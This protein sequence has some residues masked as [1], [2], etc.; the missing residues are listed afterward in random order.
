M[1]SVALVNVLDAARAL[2][3][4]PTRAT[5]DTVADWFR[6]EYLPKRGGSFNY[7]PSMNSTYDLFRGGLKTDEAVMHC[8]SNGNPKGRS[9]NADV[10]KQIGPYAEKNISTCYRVGFLAVP[11]GRIKGRI[12]YLGVKAPLVRVVHDEAF[13]VLPGYRMSY[14]PAERE[15]DVAC[16]VVLAQLGRDDY[17]A[18]DVEYL[19]AGPGIDGKRMLRVIHGKERRIFDA[20]GVDRLMDVYVKGIALLDADGVEIREPSFRGYRI[21]DPSQPSFF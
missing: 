11:V 4:E 13:F 12:I 6:R 3:Q 16:S 2:G 10:V 7:D 21:F 20:D 1:S 19:Y 14:R 9:Q 15:I 5:P 17:A 8:L 18:A